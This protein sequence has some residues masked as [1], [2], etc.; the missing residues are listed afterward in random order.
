MLFSLSERDIAIEEGREAVGGG[1]RKKEDPVL[2]PAARASIRRDAAPAPRGVPEASPGSS[3]S[4]RR[5]VTSKRYLGC[6]WCRIRLRA[7][8]P[9]VDLLDGMCPICDATLQPAAHVADVLGFG[10][11]DVGLS[12]FADHESRRPLGAHR[13]SGKGSSTP[14]QVVNHSRARVQI[15]D[16]HPS[17]L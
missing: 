13:S 5:R 9:E 1:H 3:V 2:R 16:Q 14:P 6:D 4:D 8:A 17:G 15:P 12:S 10:L 11:F 7:S